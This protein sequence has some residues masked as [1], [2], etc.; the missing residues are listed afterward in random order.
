MANKRYS[1]GVVQGRFQLIHKGHMEYF[2]EAKKRCDHLIVG[3]SDFD[4]EHTYM[5]PERLH[6]D[7]NSVYRTLKEPFHAF[8]YYERMQMIKESLME[9]GILPDTFDIVP[10]PIHEPRLLKYYIPEKSVIFV[11]VY[12]GWGDEK[13]K[14]L[15]GLGFECEV[16]WRRSMEERFTTASEVRKRMACGESWQSLVPKGVI[17]V[18]EDLCIENKI[19][20]LKDEV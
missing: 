6:L 5:D 16:L 14:I 19:K 8:T 12:D 13:M 3:I 2:V 4:P 20:G 17:T 11:T 15:E 9:E 18:I 10:F 1:V 7:S